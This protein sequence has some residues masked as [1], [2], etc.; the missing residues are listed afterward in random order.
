MR[1]LDEMNLRS[2]KSFSNLERKLEDLTND[3]N[4]KSVKC[5]SDLTKR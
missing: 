5:S 2:S 1:I 4:I 3:L